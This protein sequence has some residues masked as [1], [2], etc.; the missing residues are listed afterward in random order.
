MKIKIFIT[1]IVLL[2][3]VSCLQEWCYRPQEGQY[4]TLDERYFGAHYTL[5]QTDFRIKIL[6]SKIK[7]GCFWVELEL[8]NICKDSLVLTTSGVRIWDDR[9]P[10]DPTIDNGDSLGIVYFVPPGKKEKYPIPFVEMI[11]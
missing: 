11:L 1:V 9:R 7:Q 10:I 3:L 5:S 6:A 2:T 8:K 4:P